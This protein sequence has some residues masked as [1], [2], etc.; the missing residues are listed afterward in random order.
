MISYSPRHWF[1][2]IFKLHKAET[3]RQLYPLMIMLGLYAFAI[4]YIF[5]QFLHVTTKSKISSLS[6]MY[7][8]LG[9]VISLL[10]VFRTNT[11]YE[12]WWEGRKLWGA[13]VNCS[14]NLAMKIKAFVPEQQHEFYKHI[15]PAYA[16]ALR[17]HLQEHA[18]KNNELEENLKL[19]TGTSH[20]PN[21]IASKVWQKIS[22]EPLSEAQLI[23]LNQDWQQ[24]TEICGAC[25][26]IKNT[27]I[28]ISYSFFLKK[29]LFFY[30]MF[31][32]FAYVGI[33]DY[34]VVP[35]VVFIFYVLSSIEIIA[36]EIENP[37]GL[38]DNDLPLEKLCTVIKNSVGE[39]FDKKHNTVN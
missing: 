38:D 33:L 26:R 5:V 15:I 27:P 30:I 9:F 10:L 21:A 36:E 23:I 2:F 18:H 25:E 34:Y 3:F 31:M 32:P 19:E 24:W 28:P 6:V 11:A 1:L 35:L 37:F 13:L 39:I 14:R 8:V 4:D 29:F 16:N 20:I 22:S 17:K 12:R 7:S